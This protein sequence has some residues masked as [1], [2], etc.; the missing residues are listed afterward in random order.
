MK[1]TKFALLAAIT[2]AGA[3]LIN[4]AGVQAAGVAVSDDNKTPATATTT[5][6][7]NVKAGKLTLDAAPDFNF[8]EDLDIQEVIQKNSISQVNN[9]VSHA[10]DDSH[11][12]GSINKDAVNTLQVSDYRGAGNHWTL[13]ANMSQFTNATTNTT[14]SGVIT[15]GGSKV[16]LNDKTIATEVSADLLNSADL[17]A[18]N[19]PEGLSTVTDT[20]DSGSTLK[21]N[22]PEKIQGG[23]YDAAITWTLSDGISTTKSVG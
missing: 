10:S 3:T 9:T 13:S 16:G 18:K 12:D 11:K 20:L 21:L 2:L 15:L 1:Q 5:A 4:V 6:E 14:V 23:T 22:N 19:Y 7:F 17:D 8:G